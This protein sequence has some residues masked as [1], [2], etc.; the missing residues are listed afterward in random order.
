MREGRLV[1]ALVDIALQLFRKPLRIQ[2]DD[3][4]GDD[5]RD[6]PAADAVRL[7]HGAVHIGKTDDAGKAFRRQGHPVVT[8]S[9]ARRQQMAAGVDLYVDIG[10]AVHLLEEDFTA[11]VFPDGAAVPEIPDGKANS[12][13]PP[14]DQERV[15]CPADAAG[16]EGRVR[17]VRRPVHPAYVKTVS[18]QL[19]AVDIPVF[20]KGDA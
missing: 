17:K 19:Q 12:A 13:D 18:V 5:E 9:A 3:P 11:A 8:R 20:Q 2:A 4:E 1:A 10:R 14:A 7:V 6:A 15:F 16:A